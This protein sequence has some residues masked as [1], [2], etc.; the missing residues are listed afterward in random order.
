MYLFYV[1]DA[2]NRN[3]SV[4]IHCEKRL[5]IG[6]CQSEM[7]NSDIFMEKIARHQLLVQGRAEGWFLA[8]ELYLTLPP[9][10]IRYH[11][12][13]K[14]I[15]MYCIYIIPYLSLFPYRPGSFLTASGKMQK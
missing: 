14:Y 1:P 8:A 12:T 13:P 2:T 3:T 15:Y 7:M 4:P 5:R 10:P 9:H 6:L 11:H